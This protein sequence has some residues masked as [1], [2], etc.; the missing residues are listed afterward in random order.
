MR[1]IALTGGIAC[2]KSLFCEGLKEEGI[3]VLDAD[4]VTHRLE[5]CGGAAVE[6]LVRIFG[7]GI[8]TE[9]G[10]IDRKRLGKMVFAS[11]EARAAVN[12]VLHPLVKA[13]IARWVSE[14]IPGENRIRVAVIPL[15]FECGWEDDWDTILC[16]TS[17]E[18]N[19]V[20]RLMQTRGHSETEARQR[21][22][23]QMPVAEKAARSQLVICN[24]A[25]KASLREAAKRTAEE[26]SASSCA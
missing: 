6:P 3:A 20:K 16:L 10:S 24:D 21:I 15:L 12:A 4:D 7:N 2:G 22:A 14:E 5:A 1:R 13:E 23:S 26:L 25:D 8:L 19:Q 17:S 11:K 9:D 18:E